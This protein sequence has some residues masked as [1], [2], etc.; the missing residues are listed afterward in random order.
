[1]KRVVST[2]VSTTQM[3]DLEEVTEV[4]QWRRKE[5]DKTPCHDRSRCFDS[6]A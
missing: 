4:C 5:F 1:M 3:K 2:A 6:T